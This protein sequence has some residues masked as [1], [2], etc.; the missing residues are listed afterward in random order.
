MAPN[1]LTS[2]AANWSLKNGN[3]CVPKTLYPEGQSDAAQWGTDV[4]KLL[5]TISAIP[6]AT[7]KDFRTKL[8]I[9]IKSRQAR[10]KTAKGRVKWMTTPDLKAVLAEYRKEEKEKEAERDQPSSKQRATEVPATPLQ[11]ESASDMG[12]PR[13]HGYENSSA[14]IPYK[15]Y[16]HHGR[17]KAKPVNLNPDA[18]VAAKPRGRK[19]GR[20]NDDED[21]RAAKRPSLVHEDEDA[22]ALDDTGFLSEM[23]TTRPKRPTKRLS[24]LQQSRL[25]IP[26][27]QED[28]QPNVPETPQANAS[29]DNLH[30][31]HHQDIPS[32]IQTPIFPGASAHPGDPPDP[33]NG[34][35]ND[36]ISISMDS[37]DLNEL[38]IPAGATTKERLEFYRMRRRIWFDDYMVR[39][40]GVQVR[41]EEQKREGRDDGVGG[42]GED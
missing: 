16:I 9:A 11:E 7:I 36:N 15:P 27:W 4:L 31:A 17:V 42:F 33:E 1:S 13:S 29:E 21:G 19:R 25:R 2:I 24:R 30:V 35:V 3:E 14:P 32:I 41:E 12:M 10:N 38:K 8:R 5:E 40:L 39:M 22:R 23:H 26:H 34:D 28:I 18:S 6:A 37:V 20:Q